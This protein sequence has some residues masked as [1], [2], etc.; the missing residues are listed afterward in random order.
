MMADGDGGSS[1]R[2]HDRPVD[3]PAAP[4]PARRGAHPR[5]ARPHGVQPPHRVPRLRGVRRPDP[6]D[7]GRVLERRARLRHREERRAQGVRRHRRH[8]RHG[9]RRPPHEHLQQL[10]PRH[11]RPRPAPR[12]P[13][14]ARRLRRLHPRRP[15]RRHRAPLGAT[16]RRQRRVPVASRRDGGRVRGRRPHL[17]PP[18]GGCRVGRRR[19][20]PRRGLVPAVPEPHHRDAGLRRRRRPLRRGRRRRQLQ[21]SRTTGSVGTRVATRSARAARCGRRI[22]A[23]AGT[24]SA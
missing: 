21:R 5:P 12:L 19:A 4:P 7:V 6:A 1:R 9:R 15:P 17:P 8:D 10:G 2:P 11:A 13:G 23:P 3:G 22:C 24:R 18:A 20:R 14:G 16:R